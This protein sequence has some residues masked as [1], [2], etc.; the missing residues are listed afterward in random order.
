MTSETVTT[1]GAAVVAKI[2]PWERAGLGPAPY[3]YLGSYV[4]TYQS[5]PGCPDCPIQPGSSCDYCGQGIA[6]V[7]RV[8]IVA[9][10]GILITFILD[11]EVEPLS[12]ERAWVARSFVEVSDAL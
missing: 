2:H 3:A 10:P 6:I 12:T 5:I 9:P 11:P 8:L 1:G 7:C 4:K